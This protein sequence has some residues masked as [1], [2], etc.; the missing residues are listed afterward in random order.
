V[1]AASARLDAGE[2]FRRHAE[3]VARFLLRLGL[4]RGDIDDVVQEVFLTAHRQGGFQGEQAQ[5]T[6]WLAAI[7]VRVA[8]NH[9]RSHRRRRDQPADG[10]EGVDAEPA[11]S[12]ANDPAAVTEA[13]SSLRRVQQA[14]D[15]LDMDHRAVFVLY[16][17]EGMRGEAIAEAL[18][19][20]A[21]TV[22]SR[23]HK[24]RKRFTKAYNKL[25]EGGGPQ[26]DRRAG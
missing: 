2:L 21:G 25:L 26:G 5:P 15:T 13:R 24:A 1:T 4:P 9:K 8:S 10:E 20:P 22:Y 11:R 19:L 17:L 14:L 3:F 6:T 12:T 23:L 7:A 16:E 18:E